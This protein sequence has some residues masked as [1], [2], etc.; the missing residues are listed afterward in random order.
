[1]PLIRRSLKKS[2]YS[3]KAYKQCIALSIKSHYLQLYFFFFLAL[4]SSTLYLKWPSRV[5]FQLKCSRA[6]N[7]STQCFYVQTMENSWL[8]ES[9]TWAYCSTCFRQNSS[10]QSRGKDS[11]S[12]DLEEHLQGKYLLIS[13]GHKFQPNA[14]CKGFATEYYRLQAVNWNNMTLLSYYAECLRS[15]IS[16]HLQSCF[17]L[18]DRI[19]S[20][21]FSQF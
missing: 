17:L 11:C 14:N 19:K 15:N 21:T 1:M 9:V 20:T 12:A 3:V 6:V 16:I 7:P 2:K 8:T 13:K 5:D 4:Y 10:E 18:P